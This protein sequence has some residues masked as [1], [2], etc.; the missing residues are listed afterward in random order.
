MERRTVRIC[1]AGDHLSAW[2][3]KSIGDADIRTFNVPFRMS[4]QIRPSLSM[5]AS[6]GD[7]R[8]DKRTKWIAAHRYLDDIS[9]SEIA[10]SE[11]P[12]GI[13][14]VRRVPA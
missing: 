1:R 9:S 14:Q 10:L 4:K 6:Q 8:A 2:N 13:L 5:I 12:S 3:H 11:V 7:V